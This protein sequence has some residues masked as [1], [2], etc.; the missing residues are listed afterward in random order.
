M[1]YIYILICPL[2]K[3]I[4]YVG[5]SKTPKRRYKQ[6]LKDAEKI[7]KTEKTEK[8]KWI[9]N[10]KKHNLQP[11]IKIIK[12]VKNQI[13][14]EFEEEKIVLDNIKDIYNIHL[15]GKNHTTVKRFLELGSLDKKSIFEKQKKND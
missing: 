4:R 9:L 7:K 10:L 12:T 8:Q 11:D 15:P 3:K 1:I 14:G 6:H 2:T 13:D 5:Q